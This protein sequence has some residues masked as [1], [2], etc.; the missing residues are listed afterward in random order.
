MGEH[1]R[2]KILGT[3]LQMISDIHQAVNMYPKHLCPSVRSKILLPRSFR[4]INVESGC[5]CASFQKSSHINLA[6]PK[7]ADLGHR[8]GFLPAVTS[9]DSDD[10]AKQQ[11]WY[12]HSSMQQVRLQ[13]KACRAIKLSNRAPKMRPLFASCNLQSRTARCSTAL[14]RR[15]THPCRTP[16]NI[17]FSRHVLAKKMQLDSQKMLGNTC[18]NDTHNARQC[19]L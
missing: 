9:D 3:C 12:R 4:M 18:S 8:C 14:N 11:T 2:R 16:A 6:C 7:A 13:R 17:P 15:G 10:P 1:D 5:S 19:I